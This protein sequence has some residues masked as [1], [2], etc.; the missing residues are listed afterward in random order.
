MFI[1]FCSSCVILRSMKSRARESPTKESSRY[2]HLK[3]H[4]DQPQK[5]QGR[6]TPRDQTKRVTKK[7]RTT[8]VNYNMEE[9]RR[10]PER[11]TERQDP[12]KSRCERSGVRRDRDREKREAGGVVC[13]TEHCIM[14]NFLSSWTVSVHVSCLKTCLLCVA[15]KSEAGVCTW[16]SRLKFRV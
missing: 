16:E 4:R 6:K 1:W 10:F 9:A 7:N 5:Q 14:V 8:N 13:A 2:T 12:A 3:K 15:Q 11:E